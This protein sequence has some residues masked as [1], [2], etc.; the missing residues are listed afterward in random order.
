MVVLKA[1]KCP[2][3]ALSLTNRVVLH[4]S[5][6][7]AFQQPKHVTVNFGG[8]AFPFPVEADPTMPPG[9]VRSCEPPVWAENFSDKILS[10]DP[11]FM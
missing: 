5:D 2:S 3:E 8:R 4:T 6:H 9:Q 7:A 1:G 10:S 11:Y